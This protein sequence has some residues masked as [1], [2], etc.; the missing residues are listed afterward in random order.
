MPRHLLILGMHRSGT[1]LVARACDTA[2]ISAGPPEEFLSAQDDNPDGFY[3]SR[4][5]VAINESVLAE[6][7]GTWS[8]PPESMASSSLEPEIDGFLRALDGKTAG[9]ALLKD[10]RLCLTWPSWTEHLSNPAFVFVYRSPLAVANSLKRRNSFPLQ[11]GLLLW[12][13]YNR[14][15]L[16]CLKHGSFEAISYDT[17][18]EKSKSL[19]ALLECLKDRGFECDPAGAKDLFVSDQRHHILDESTPEHALLTASQRYLH[20]YCVALCETGELSD[21]DQDACDSEAS[22]L[23]RLKDLADALEPLATIVETGR[24]RDEALALV[25]ERTVERDDVLDSIARLEADHKALSGAHDK[26]IE[27]RL[28]AAAEL[29]RLNKEHSVLSAAHAREVSEHSNLV[30]LHDKLHDDFDHRGVQLNELSD[31]KARLEGDKSRLE[32][33]VNELED[34]SNFLFYSLTEAHRTLLQFETSFLSRVQRYSRKAYRLLTLQRGKN[35][36][37][38]DLLAQAHSHFSEFELAVPERQPNKID[39][40]ADVARYVWRNPSGSARS[41][42]WARLKAAAG[43]FFTKSPGDLQVWINARFPENADAHLPAFAEGLSP[44]LDELCLDFDRHEPPV[45]SIIVPVY[46]DYRVTI[47]CLQS[48]YEQT[49]DVT[50]EVI[51]ADDCSNDFTTSI[52]D[53]VSG[54]SVIRTEQN[55]R[56]LGNCNNA[57]SHARGK[58]LLFLNNDTV[59]TEGWLE[60]LLEPMADS[61]VGVTGP[62]LLFGDGKLQEAGGILWRDASGWNFGRGD[63]PTKPAYEY[64]RPVDYVSGACLL[65]RHSLWKELGGFDELFAPAYYEDADLCFSARRSGYQVMYVPESVVYHFEG[66]SNGTDL[67]SGVKQYQ[68]VNQQRFLDKWRDE[69]ELNHFEN[70]E[71]VIHARDR[72]AGKKSVL[73]IDHYVPHY[74][75]DAGGRSTYLYIKLLLSQGYR[76]QLMGANFFPHEPYTSHFREMGVEVLVGEYMARNLDSWLAEHAP[77]ID[78]IFLHR[79]HIA[80]QFLPHLEKMKPRPPISFFGHDLHH[81]RIER[82]AKLKGDKTLYREAESW[83]KREL[84]VIERVD[85]AYYFSSVE[86]EE[87]KASVPHHKLRRIPL[88][89]LDIEDQPTY[90]P[91]QINDVLFVGGYNHPPNVDAALWLTGTIMPIVRQSIPDARLHLIGSNPPAT[92]LE[93]DDDETVVHGY[94]SDEELQRLYRSVG[95]AVVPLQYGAGVKGKVIEAV[96]AGVPLVTTDVGAEGLPDADSVMWVENTAEGIAGALVEIIGGS[97]DVA[98]KLEPQQRWLASNFDRERAIEA[99]GVTG[100][101]FD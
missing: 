68:V 91:S 37:Y 67:N 51:V 48:I 12:E 85:F 97:S 70:A 39:M 23:C 99:L 40:A 47:N 45:V 78:Q 52:S 26:E 34:K 46:N 10:P 93:L 54:I 57:A 13:Y 90:E 66:V 3:E 98:S 14:R 76:V 53:R 33:T 8:S 80:E 95:A 29:E 6:A 73:V 38:E 69:L 89:A 30:S 9:Q 20:Q 19:V 63:D 81:L 59:V 84:A 92:V 72:S 62:K 82:E 31:E 5:L 79:P 22:I 17:I 42:S 65:I 101:T 27:A 43:F 44:A 7:G 35:S 32:V 55:L 96:A 18:D 56:F 88:Y 25:V 36:A 77:Y 41:F 1:S 60:R 86:V 50:Y 28:V 64:R 49:S 74:D 94:V 58:F 15:A 83:K 2:G 16:A 24:E 11:L 100:A 4:H 87:L 75:K 71:H 61:G 21:F